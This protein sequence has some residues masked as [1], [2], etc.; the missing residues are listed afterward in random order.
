LLLKS[1]QPQLLIPPHIAEALGETT[2]EHEIFD[3]IMQAEGEVFRDVPGRRT[4][5]VKLAKKFYFIKQH[6]GVGWGEIFKNLLTLRLPVLSAV[7]EWRAIEKLNEI[8]IPTT[9]AVAYGVRGNSPAQL[10]SFLITQDL[11]DIVSLETL[12][13]DWR[14]NPPGARF[15]RH[16]IL[17]VAKVARLLHDNGLNHRDFYIC[18]LCLDKKRLAAGEIYLY[19]IDLHRVGI[20]AHISSSARMKDMAALYFSAMDIGLRRR[21][22]LRFL[23]AYR[24]QSVRHTLATERSF[25]TKVSVRARQLYL[26]FHHVL[27]IENFLAEKTAKESVR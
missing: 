13:A 2:P 11:G 25:W 9:P 4:I 10:Q 6:F 16:L 24:Q 18:H 12:C 14:E 23:R 27:P 3:H 26:K 15:K 19:L 17:A 21:D 20:H 7:T 8:G 5:K 1:T 22:Y